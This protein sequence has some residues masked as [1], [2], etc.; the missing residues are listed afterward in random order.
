MTNKTA[1]EM[2]V[3]G[4]MV[5]GN[6]TL[7]AQMPMGKSITMSGYIYS[8]STV[9]AINK[10]VDLMHDVIDRQR[11]RAEIPELEAKLDQKKVACQ[12]LRDSLDALEAKSKKKKLSTQEQNNLENGLISLR[13]VMQDIEDGVKAIADA[14]AKV[15]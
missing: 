10:Q 14:K 5:T 2:V 12:Q 1:S 6:F 4:D 11:L 3:D 15:I 13:R 8:T 9:D 7:Q